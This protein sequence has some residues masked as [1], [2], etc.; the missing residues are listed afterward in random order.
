LQVFAAG[1]FHLNR[2]A[3][4]ARVFRLNCHSVVHARAAKTS[5]AQ[6]Y[7]AKVFHFNH[8]ATDHAPAAKVFHLN[9]CHRAPR[10]FHLHHHVFGQAF[11]PGRFFS[12]LK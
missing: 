12:E 4:A 8:R 9:R 2:H 5:I 6:A 11:A 10:I 1:I 3:S 7:A